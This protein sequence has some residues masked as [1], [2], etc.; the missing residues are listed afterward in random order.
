MKKKNVVI[1]SLSLIFVLLLATS[2]FAREN[3]FQRTMDT[4][5][6]I[7]SLDFLDN[8]EA[9]LG[10]FLRG[11]IWI[12]VFIVIFNVVNKI[13]AGSARGTM[14]NRGS[15]IVLAGVFAT[16]TSIFLPPGFLIALGEGYSTVMAAILIGILAIFVLVITYQVLPGLGLTGRVLAAVRIAFLLVLLSLL[17]LITGYVTDNF[18]VVTPFIPSLMSGKS[19]WWRK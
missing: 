17:D 5:L 15:A 16:L 13:G 3:I 18:S 12:T 4:L 1:L 2:V 14:F 11:I 6:S 9:K 19:G 8:D 10:A 7:F